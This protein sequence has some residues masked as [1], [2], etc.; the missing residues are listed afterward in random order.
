MK[1][2]FM[3]TPDFAV[4]VLEELIKKHD[5]VAVVSQPDK[6]KGRGKK[7]QPTPVKAVAVENN[8]PVYQPKRIKNEEFVEILKGIE[9][10]VY[11]VVAYG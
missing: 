4:P 11:V 8:I 5:V 6:P 7:L 9:A 10:D 2:L 3:G 1:V